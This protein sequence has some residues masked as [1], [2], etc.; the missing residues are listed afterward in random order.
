MSVDSVIISNKIAYA[1]GYNI[2]TY[3]NG[4]DCSHCKHIQNVRQGL[5]TKIDDKFFISVLDKKTNI[6]LIVFRSTNKFY[7]SFRLVLNKH[8]MSDTDIRY[9]YQ[10]TR[11]FVSYMNQKYGFKRGRFVY[12]SNVNLTKHPSVE[13]K[14]KEHQHCW[15]VYDDHDTLDDE[16]FDR[17]F[18]TIGGI[19]PDSRERKKSIVVPIPYDTDIIYRFGIGGDKEYEITKYIDPSNFIDSMN[20]FIKL[21]YDTTPVMLKTGNDYYLFM[22][23]SDGK[24]VKI[25]ISTPPPPKELYESYVSRLPKKEKDYMQGPYR[26]I[27]DIHATMKYERREL[28]NTHEK[29]IIKECQ[30]KRLDK[31]I[32]SDLDDKD[33]SSY[34]IPIPTIEIESSRSMIQDSDRQQQVSPF[35]NSQLNT[36]FTAPRIPRFTDPRRVPP[37]DNTPVSSRP[38]FTDPRKTDPSIQRPPQNWA[39]IASRSS[40]FVTQSSQRPPQNW[41][42]V[43]NTGTA[44]IKEPTK[45]ITS[46][47]ELRRQIQMNADRMVRAMDK[48]KMDGTKIDPTA[49]GNQFLPIPQE[50]PR[51][52]VNRQSIE[53]LKSLNAPEIPMV[54]KPPKQFEFKRFDEDEG[55]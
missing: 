14:N 31:K 55:F 32:Q 13:G 19:D 54:S 21:W 35:A 38:K 20:N 1:G 37:S 28:P 30:L 50:T 27:L 7:Y 25:T 11:A 12:N 17:T 52:R 43:V 10:C 44:I 4:K 18:G 41:A 33:L 53:Q 2:P 6:G 23:F 51:V 24:I 36:Q 8:I 26:R 47:D 3:S 15:I 34:P 16:L 5:P 39:Q 46:P 45:T 29:E 42:Q 48:Q 9:L 22:Y 49:I 40:E